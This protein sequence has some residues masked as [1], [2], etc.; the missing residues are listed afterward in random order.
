MTIGNVKIPTSWDEMYV[1]RFLKAG[2][3][4]DKQV[5]LTIDR[6]FVETMPNEKDGSEKDRGIMCFKETPLQLAL[7]RTNGECLKALFGKKVQTWV[8]KRVT[9]AP[10]MTKFGKDDVEAIRVVGSPNLTHSI[11][12]EIK[13]PKRKPQK[14]TLVPTG[15]GNQNQNQQSAPV[16][17]SD[18]ASDPQ[19]VKQEDTN[20]T[21]TEQVSQ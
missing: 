19:N 15:K 10:E 8:G 18:P 13:M 11:D 4:K 16:P 9:I 3:L 17:P 21:A 6:V 14:R 1:G 2:L 20:T 5:T 7:N 12:I